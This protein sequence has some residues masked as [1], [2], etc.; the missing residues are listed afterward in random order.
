ME[1]YEWRFTQRLRARDC[2]GYRPVAKALCAYE[3]KARPGA[4][5]NTITL[6][7]IIPPLNIITPLNTINLQNIILL[8]NIVTPQ[9]SPKK[10]LS[11]LT[12]PN[13]ILFPQTI[14]QKM[15]FSI[16]N[17]NKKK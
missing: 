7:N 13:K 12:P 1:T 15:K 9:N 2:S 14:L 4:Q 5:I 3:R 10:P 6:L 11:S 17:A 16:D 8:Q